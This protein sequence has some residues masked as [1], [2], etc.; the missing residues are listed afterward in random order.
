MTALEALVG[1]HGDGW[2]FGAAP[3]LADCYLIP[4]IYSARRFNVPLEAFPHLLLMAF[5][6]REAAR[7]AGIWLHLG[8]LAV[9]RDEHA[10]WLALPGQIDDCIARIDQRRDR[11]RDADDLIIVLAGILE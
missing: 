8:S 3:T 9:L 6:Q 1:R 11:Y 7:A 10:V 2:C 5:L 4:Q